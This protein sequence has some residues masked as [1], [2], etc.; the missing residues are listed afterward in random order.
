MRVRVAAG[1]TAAAAAESPNGRKL[2]GLV[3]PFGAEASPAVGPSRISVASSVSAPSSRIWCN[4]EHETAAPVGWVDPEDWTA[5][6]SG[7][8]ATVHLLPTT[9]AADLWQ[10]VAAGA[11]SGL[12]VELEV[13]ASHETDGLHVITDGLITGLASVVNPAF[14]DARAVAA[15]AVSEPNTSE[16]LPADTDQHVTESLTKEHRMNVR[17]GAWIGASA[18]QDFATLDALRE[19][20]Q[21]STNLTKLS[22]VPGMLPE[23]LVGPILRLYAS[24]SP[25]FN[26]LGGKAAPEAQSFRVPVVTG[27][28][29]AA[30]HSPEGSD[31]TE[32][33]TIGETTVTMKALKRAVSLSAEAVLYS[34]FDIL[35][36]G[37]GQLIDSLVTGRE[38]WTASTLEAT[39]GTGTVVTVAGDGSDV[40]D[41]LADAR[42]GMMKDIGKGPDLVA[43]SLDSWAKLAGMTNTLGSPL[44]SG[45]TQDLTST[46]ATLYGLPVVVSPLSTKSYLISRS[47]VSS[48]THPELRI[49]SD[50]AATLTYTLGGMASVGLAVG[51]PLGLREIVIG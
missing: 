7:L 1:L 14:D 31:V 32:K 25:L 28:L 22:D 19:T 21:A 10:E 12:S 47:V 39:T 24:G 16:P 29:P 15:A 36:E 37:L 43:L 23:P 2:H 38:T 3:L 8:S 40:W 13:I 9:A 34:Q 6:D 30:A 42:T 17:A 45:V 35:E 4:R 20:V 49:R 27:R 18:R 41:A 48:W 5:T 11:R 51:S 44:I 50:Q 26:A 46:S 33:F